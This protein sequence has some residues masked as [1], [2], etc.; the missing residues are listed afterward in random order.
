MLILGKESGKSRIRRKPYILFDVRS[1]T[2]FLVTR[3]EAFVFPKTSRGIIGKDTCTISYG[4]LAERGTPARRLFRYFVSCYFLYFLTVLFSF[5]QV[6]TI[7]SRSFVYGRPYGAFVYEGCS[8]DL[9]WRPVV[10]IYTTL[11]LSG[12]S[13][14]IQYVKIEQTLRV[15]LCLNPQVLKSVTFLSK[16]LRLEGVLS[17]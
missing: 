15:V 12:L 8:K 11:C 5:S 6:L 4:S 17:Y 9:Y 14:V 16:T 1:N 7:S 2:N 13:S 10:A 3:L